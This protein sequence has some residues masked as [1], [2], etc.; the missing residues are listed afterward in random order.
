[1]NLFKEIS[2]DSADTVLETLFNDDRRFADNR[3][4]RLLVLLQQL[5]ASITGLETIPEDEFAEVIYAA[6]RSC[7]FVEP[8][9]SYQVIATVLNALEKQHSAPERGELF[10]L[11]CPF[12]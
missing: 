2:Q 10:T 11:H 9:E 5:E 7:G 1:M 3:L 12:S 6:L 8:V 4:G